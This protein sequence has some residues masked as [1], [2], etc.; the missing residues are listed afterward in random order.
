MAF[1]PFP[2]KN[3]GETSPT[4]LDRQN[5][6]AAEEALAAQVTSGA[7]APPSSVVS[8]SAMP[9][10]DAT[11]VTDYANIKAAVV[12]ASTSLPGLPK[13]V[14]LGPGEF[15]L[16]Q[17]VPPRSGVSVFGSQGTTIKCV[18]NF[19][20][21]Q[22]DQTA[23]NLGFEAFY[24]NFAGPLTIQPCMP[25]RTRGS[26]PL[27]VALTTAPQTQIVLLGQAT[28][29]VNGTQFVM[30]NGDTVT[31][32][33]AGVVSTVTASNPVTGSSAPGV[34]PMYNTTVPVTYTPTSGMAVNAMVAINALPAN[35]S[36]SG[37]VTEVVLTGTITVPSG[38][39][40]VFPDGTTTTA[41]AAATA[42]SGKTTVPVKS[43]TAASTFASGSGI[44]IGPAGMTTAIVYEGDLKYNSRAAGAP[45]SGLKQATDFVM[46]HCTVQNT[47][48][49]PWIASGVRGITRTVSNRAVNTM[50]AGYLFCD[51]VICSNNYSLNSA[52][53]AFSI[54]RGC[55]SFTA[56]GNVCEGSC[57]NGIWGAGFFTDIGPSNGT[58]TGNT[59]H[60]VGYQ[61]VNLNGAPSSITVTGNTLDGGYNYGPIDKPA[62]SPLGTVPSFGCGVYIG[63]NTVAS[64]SG[65]TA[66]TPSTITTS[67]NHGLSS[68]DIVYLFGVGG[69]V[70]ASG[71]Q[72]VTVLTATTF[73]IPATVTGAYTSGGSL[74]IPARGISVKDNVIKRCSRIGVFVTECVGYDIGPNLHLD[75][76]MQY[77]PDGVTEI[78]ASSTITN[79]GVV[80]DSANPS[81][82]QWGNVSGNL[83]IDMRPTPYMNFVVTPNKREQSTVEYHNN[84]QF[85]VRGSG[86]SPREEGIARIFDYLLQPT[87][88]VTAGSNGAAGTVN[89]FIT[90][91]AAGSTRQMAGVQT[92][93][94]I[95]WLLEASST[96]EGGGNVGTNLELIAYSD[97]GT[98]LATLLTMTRLGA[99]T[100]GEK[101]QP[102]TVSS[103]LVSGAAAATVAAGAQASKAEA[104]G[105]GANDTAGTVNATA[106]AS[107]ATG[108]LATITFATAYSATPHVTLSS[109][110][111]AS[112]ACQPY[113]SSRS[114]TGFSISANVAAAK[115][116]SLQFDYHV[117]G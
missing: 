110:N 7:I 102:L 107:P 70:G 56:T 60:N 77:Q 4:P 67:T 54:S 103:R 89:G 97:T 96:A 43:Y 10:G 79:C 71:L 116:A 45:T 22:T 73:T 16:S 28:A 62:E 8:G 95:R 19:P 32:T 66:G 9:S 94:V 65:V 57:Y 99:I 20:A 24:I 50:D 14:L 17:A 117:V 34:P 61:C 75:I 78:A 44:S 113:V 84:M 30:P 1:S 92:A 35:A 63:G 2:W 91:G 39:V 31:A 68:G 11:G 104:A 12:A 23:D 90:N 106:L 25:Q 114:T 40:V 47:W 85:G 93:G 29:I 76:G 74:C 82:M 5:L 112:A 115:E 26:L 81:S 86:T 72:V 15:T 98:A 36:I 105:N 109:A 37:T 38:G 80:Q 49:L 100:I 3:K 18:G 55:K 53:N 69:A 51:E 13:T 83:A 111:S 59:V 42:A 101:G 27:A 64:I 21:F 6:N 58:I 88:G 46:E 41:S 48:T 108:V 87:A 52:D 33:G